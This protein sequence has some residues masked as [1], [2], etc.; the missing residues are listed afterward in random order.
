MEG[1]R[2]EPEWRIRNEYI[3]KGVITLHTV[4]TPNGNAVAY[5]IVCLA[6]PLRHS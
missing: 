2:S 3:E 1:L 5:V 4:V 6:F